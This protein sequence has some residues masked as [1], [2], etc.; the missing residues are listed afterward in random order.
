M[1]ETIPT[2]GNA[3][4]GNWLAQSLFSRTVW[5]FI[6][7]FGGGTVIATLKTKVS[8]LTQPILYGLTTAAAIGVI[9]FTLTGQAVFSKTQPQTDAD[10]VD[11]NI[12]AWMASLGLGWQPEYLADASF[13]YRVKLAN[14]SAVVV[15]YLPKR[16]PGYVQFEGLVTM[17]PEHKA[18]L[19]KLNN[20]QADT[21]LAE[22]SLELA[23]SRIGY[24]VNGGPN[25]RQ[26]ESVNLVKGIPIS[27]LSEA[28]FAQNLDEID[29]TSIIVRASVPLILQRI[30][31]QINLKSDSK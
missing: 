29:S 11:Q 6:L 5:E 28:T 8:A 20:E 17:A 26:L 21:V 23:R 4:D 27:S 15:D 13:A 9:L 7:M 2:K 18:M 31:S 25:I 12:K 22:L 3:M 16:R 14:G 30:N 10:N 19:A 24:Q 1:G